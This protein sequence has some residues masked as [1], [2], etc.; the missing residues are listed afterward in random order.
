MVDGLL[1]L[2]PLEEVRAHFEVNV[3]DSVSVTQ[4][5]LP[6][7]G[8]KRPRTHEPGRILNTCSVGGEIASLFSALARDQTRR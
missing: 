7:L 2:Q 4:G 8:V 1:T 3:I 5:F 6:L